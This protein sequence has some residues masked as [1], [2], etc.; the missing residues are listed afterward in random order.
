M[1]TQ[2]R[3]WHFERTENHRYT[4]HQPFGMLFNVLAKDTEATTPL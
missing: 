3:H 2:L 4:L 1:D